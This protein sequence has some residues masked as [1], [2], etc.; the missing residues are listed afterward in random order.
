[1][2]EEIKSWEVGGYTFS[3]ERD[4]ELARKEEQQVKFLE[5]RMRYD[6][7]E[8][9]LAVYNKA[10]DSRLFSTPVGHAYLQKIQNYLKEHE[11]MAKARPI[12][13]YQDYTYDPHEKIRRREARAYVEPSTYSSLK[14]K[15]RISLI[16]NVVLAIAV[17]AMF[18]I[19]LTSDNP[20]IL[21]YQ[22]AIT[23]HYAAW[24]QDLTERE[25]AIRIK[26][27]E[28]N[29]QSPALSLGDKPVVVK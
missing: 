16:F 13:L 10:V 15:I 2:A 6:K 25:N 28:L 9:V 24:E 12:R 3:S 29:I 19:T 18:V 14:M 4:A 5:K 7:P 8:V 11:M 26:E 1:M 20:N 22:R 17:I 27:H 23:D 21:N